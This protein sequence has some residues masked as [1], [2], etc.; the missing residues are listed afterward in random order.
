MG[1]Q[2]TIRSSPESSTAAFKVG[3]GHFHSQESEGFIHFDEYWSWKPGMS[4]DCVE[5][6]L[7]RVFESG[8]AYVALS[9]ARSLAGLRVLDFDP[10]VVRA[11]PSVLHFYRQ[12]RRHQLL[13]QDSL[14]TY[15][16]ADEK[17]NVKC[18]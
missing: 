1:L 13:T 11:D 8:Q 16:D 3:M 5:I 6:S 10:K 12:L 18:S 9:R 17:E 4:L 15:S 7:S 14:H 2:R